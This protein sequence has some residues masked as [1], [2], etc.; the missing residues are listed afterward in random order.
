MSRRGRGA[1]RLAPVVAAALSTLL[2]RDAGAWDS[3]CHEWPD[4]T[5]PVAQLGAPAGRGCEGMVAARGRWRDPV[6]WL[7]EHRIILR[8]A[9]RQAGLPEALLETIV[10][11][12][13]TL[14]NQVDTGGGRMMPT[15]WPVPLDY[16]NAV[17]RLERRGFALDELA[18]LPDFSYSLADWAGGNERCPV[19]ELAGNAVIGGAVECHRFRTHMGA[20]N[21][22]HFPPQSDRWYRW[23]HGLARDRA[24]QCKAMRAAAWTGFGDAT[25]AG[26]FDG[27]WTTIWRECEVE[28]LAIEAVAQHY[29]QD[30]WS[31]GHMWQRW[32]S[33]RLTDFPALMSTDAGAA[34][35]SFPEAGR[36]LM[37]GELVALFA[38]TIHGSDGPQYEASLAQSFM[39]MITPSI[40]ADAA[41]YP[42]DESIAYVAGAGTAPAAGDMHLHDVLGDPLAAQLFGPN[43][44]ALHDHYDS[45]LTPATHTASAALAPQ[46]TALT[47]CATASVREI[48]DHLADPA[49]FGA[50]TFGAPTGA[51]PAPPGPACDAPR[52]SARGLAA[53]VENRFW[54]SAKYTIALRND[55]VLAPVP[56]D[57]DARAFLAYDETRRVAQLLAAYQPTS[58]AAAEL[59]WTAFDY[60]ERICTPTPPDD[61]C[62]W[63]TEH[64]T[65]PAGQLRFLGVQANGSYA[66]AAG[67]RPADVADPPLPWGDPAMPQALADDSQEQVLA[68]T[69]HRAHAPLWCARTDM[70][71]LTAFETRAQ[72]APPARKAEACRMCTEIVSR[73]VRPGAGG[74]SL[75]E[76]LQPG[77]VVLAGDGDAT[78]VAESRC[79]CADTFAAIADNGLT[80]VRAAPTGALAN[81]GGPY[82]TGALARDAT[83][84]S[85]NRIFVTN[86]AGDIVG[87]RWAG[88]A[89]PAA[90]EMDLTPTDPGTTRFHVGGDPRGVAFVE[91]LGKDWLLVVDNAS[92]LL[93]VYDLGD[94]NLE[95]FELCSTVDVGRDPGRVEGTWDLVVKAD[96]SR[97]YV[98]IRGTLVNP[99]DAIAMIDLLGLFTCDGQNPPVTHV[100]TFGG[101]QGLGAMA[102]SPDQQYLAVAAR[103]RNTCLDRA[104]TTNTGATIIDV[105]VGCDLVYVL[106]VAQLAPGPLAATAPVTFGARNSFPTRPVSYPYAVAWRPDGSEV[107][108]GSFLGFSPWPLYADMNAQ[109]AVA[110]GTIAAP[111]FPSPSGLLHWSYNASLGGSVAGETVEFTG[112]GQY[113]VAGAMDGTLYGMPAT[114][115]HDFWQGRESDPETLLHA[116]PL[117]RSWYGGCRVAGPCPGGFCPRSCPTGA[118]DA[119]QTLAIGSP[120]RKLLRL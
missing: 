4:P 63:S 64:R 79:G 6:H 21:A 53:G 45:P 83:R 43:A 51:A 107:A 26:A 36:R 60:D 85:R 8:Q 96:G 42:T 81:V 30:S 55:A 46:L 10:L 27:R 89:N 62:E 94:E 105:Q 112:D 108:Y 75:C 71:E 17:A 3:I 111:A 115:S 44:A 32:G 61:H 15:L 67:V 16:G 113:V 78:R 29:L 77:S 110:L 49:T 48:Y 120:I 99:G 80:F 88:V 50:A 109:G 66:P 74:K 59:A 41:C 18:E 103:L 104:Y 2:A 24:D 13:P 114:P 86:G 87:L 1:A 91:S 40:L 35:N 33:P 31:S 95:R 9:I 57:I 5:K 37:V 73:H 23:M 14:G 19:P 52:L 76:V 116:G 82:P 70:A 25:L 98:S 68:S 106:R 84:A 28:A 101:G 39:G 93:R 90:V 38:G 22:P 7:D 11:A 34:W 65:E 20:L 119:I 118:T 12:V 54:A 72:S 92:D 102:F 97:A 58:T 47:G 100:T 117:L 69:F 56:A